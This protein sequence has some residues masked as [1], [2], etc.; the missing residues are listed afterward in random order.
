MAD[1]ISAFITG[2]GNW[3]PVAMGTALLAVAALQAAAWG[4]PDSRRRT[5]ASM[6]LF[7]GVTLAIMGLGHLLAVAIKHSQGALAAPA[8]LLYLIGAAI[9]APASAISLHTR[10]ILASGPGA[11]AHTT[12][13]HA[14]MAVTLTVLGLVNLPLAIPAL[15]TIAYSR[16]ARPAAGRAVLVLFLLVCAGLF[17]GGV[18]FMAS[19]ARTFEEFQRLRAG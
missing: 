2:E 12:R 6:N 5:L 10:A 15:L 18:L 7:V 4:G 8:P 13:L 16:L 1:R 19:G 3:L 17:A 14:W 11:A 9:L